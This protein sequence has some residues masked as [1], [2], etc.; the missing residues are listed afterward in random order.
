MQEVVAR[1][2]LTL[3]RESNE[4]E[5]LQGRQAAIGA[6]RA[7]HVADARFC[8]R[9][10]DICVTSLKD[11]G[12]QHI[13]G[14]TTLDL[15]GALQKDAIKRNVTLAV[16]Q[17]VESVSQLQLVNRGFHK[18]AKLIARPSIGQGRACA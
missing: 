4:L 8:E 14:S 9:Q 1:T 16:D 10:L 5:R 18:G 13:R 2:H 15:R 11:C 17:I 6:A 12:L 7:D 3:E